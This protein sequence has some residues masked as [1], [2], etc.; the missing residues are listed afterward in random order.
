[1]PSTLP[2]T[3]L[4]LLG[5]IFILNVTQAYFTELIFDE[6][7]YWHYA[8]NITFGYFD[9]PPMVAWFIALSSLIFE[10]HLGVRFVSCLLSVG[11]LLVLWKT[12]DHPQKNK[13]ATHFV[14]LAFSMTLL[15][16]YG[17]LTLP[18]TPLLFFCA[19]FLLV[20]KRFVEK[21]GIGLAIA[22][23]MVMAALMYSKYHAV[24]IIVFVLLSNLKLLKNTY[25]W[26]AVLVALLAYTPHFLWLYEQ[27]FISIKYHL[28]ERKNG[29]YDFN[30]YTL[31]FLVNLV[32]LFGFTFPWIYR[33]LF[34]TRSKDVFTKAL[35]F[36][37]YGVLLFFFISSFN[38]RV[39]TQWI[40]VVS[41]PLV[42]LVFRDMMA[43]ETSRKWIYRMGILNIVILLY[44]RLG[45]VFEPLFPI[46][47]ESHGNKK[48]V[49]QLKD[50]VGDTPV[51][52]ENSYRLAPMYAY[53]S[54]NTSFSLNNINYRQNQY[55]LDDSERNVQ[56]RKVYY[57]SPFLKNAEL[58]F[59]N[60]KGKPY[61]GHYINQFES[62]RKLRCIVD[63][64][65][66]SLD[67]EKERL[68]KIFNP[69]DEDIDLQKLKFAVG[70]L[71][72]YKQLQEVIPIYVSAT[73]E[74]ISVLKS[75]DTTNFTFRLPPPKTKTPD[76]FRL[77]ISEKDL[78][79]GLN[80]KT[81]KLD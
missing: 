76:Y 63:G 48:W 15:N 26:L 71:D 46:Y 62:F 78:R 7:Y 80:G 31:G 30:K 1:M 55:S 47:Y 25:A 51:V 59:E 56:L 69:Y 68:V 58:A 2:K 44:L 22:L 37:T 42:I 45:L 54:G 32:A 20:Y 72:D 16:A 12:I 61:F 57:V 29:P 13:Y 39:Q 28:S 50:K 19:L 38:R 77:S 8:R 49:Q 74:N 4:Y 52:F 17:F 67:T 53:Y 79:F 27:D 5:A 73:D 35:L 81:I 21:P 40:I 10:G 3:L 33:S 41:I 36:L 14:V 60:A 65:A 64:D 23:G 66:F 11:T 75:N 9:H 43:D 34:R 70:Y 18:D 6:A 24:L